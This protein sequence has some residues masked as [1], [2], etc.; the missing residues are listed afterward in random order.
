M[1][2]GTLFELPSLGSMS[3]EALF[4]TCCAISDVD[5]PSQLDME[6]EHSFGKVSSSSMLLVISFFA[7]CNSVLLIDG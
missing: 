5:D 2:E 1:L 4:K 6:S 7:Y 3:R